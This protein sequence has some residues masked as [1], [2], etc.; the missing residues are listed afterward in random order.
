[1]CVTISKKKSTSAGDNV[2]LKKAAMVPEKKIT[3][4]K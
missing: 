4:S 2:V 1:M 3:K